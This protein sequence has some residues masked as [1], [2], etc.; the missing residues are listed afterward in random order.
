MFIARGCYPS[1]QDSPH[2]ALHATGLGQA[3]RAAPRA[4]PG[5][6]Y[7]TLYSN[8]VSIARVVPGCW[9]CAVIVYGS[10]PT[11]LK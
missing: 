8:L 11:M 1:A 10:G 7:H 4:I 5:A 9:I 2:A 6:A 3:A